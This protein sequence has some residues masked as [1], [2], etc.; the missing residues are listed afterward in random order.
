MHSDKGR[1][2]SP[3]NLCA[4]FLASSEKA[5]VSD[6]HSSKIWDCQCHCH[7]STVLD[8][9]KELMHN[10]PSYGLPRWCSAKESACQCK[11]LRRVGFDPWAGKI[12]PDLEEEVATHP[13]AVFLP[14]KS[15]GQRSL[16]GYSPGGHKESDM[17]AFTHIH[18]NTTRIHS[19]SHDSSLPSYLLALWL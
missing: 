3:H 13:I 2:E 4:C 17:T 10:S 6:N 18:L 9:Q 16:A 7:E 8:P 15:H 19:S 11:R 1:T 12:S 14:E 5:G